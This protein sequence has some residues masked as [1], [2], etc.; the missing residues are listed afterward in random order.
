MIHAHIEYRGEVGHLPREIKSIR[1]EL[2]DELRPLLLELIG[3]L[4]EHLKPQEVSCKM[5]GPAVIESLK[6]TKPCQF[7]KVVEIPE[8]Q[9]E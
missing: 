7:I 1:F 4:N 3:M 5:K 8:V 2:D 9:P 6:P